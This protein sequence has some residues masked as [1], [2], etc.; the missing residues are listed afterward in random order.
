VKTVDVA[1]SFGTRNPL[2][3]KGD[4]LAH[5]LRTFFG[6]EGA[7]ADEAVAT[8]PSKVAMP[9]IKLAEVV[10]D[11]PAGCWAALSKAQDRV[12][13]IGKTLHEALEAGKQSGE[14]DPIVIKVSRTRLVV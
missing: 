9:P 13:A 5:F 1:L 6:A 3:T 2:N 10:R 7:V 12:I 14:K 11:V 4:Q 8:A